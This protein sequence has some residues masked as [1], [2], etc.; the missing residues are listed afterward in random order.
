MRRF[1]V[2]I[3]M[4]VLGLM[5]CR[6][7]A[8]AQQNVLRAGVAVSK[9]YPFTKGAEYLAAKLRERTSGRVTLEVFPDAVL[10][11]EPELFEQV[12]G[13][14]LDISVVSANYIGVFA[15]EGNL[16]DLPFLLK[17]LAHRE[18]VTE[19]PIG[20]QY[21]EIIEKKTG[22]V[23]LGYFGGSVRNVLC[24]NRAVNSIQ[25]LQGIKIRAQPSAMI[26]DAWKAIGMVPVPLAYPE[27]YLALKT[28]VVECAEN[29]ALTFSLAKWAEVAKN[30]GLTQHTITI[31][32]LVM[33]AKSLTKLSS[34][35]QE[36]LRTVAREAVKYEVNLEVE[37]DKM[38]S[39][40]LAQKYGVKTTTPDRQPFIE[41][42]KPIAE[43]FAKSVGLEATLQEIYK[44]A[45]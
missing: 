4:I 28:G 26:V 43:E 44:M 31:K 40:L 6:G 27:V 12:R 1:I 45:K 33:S 30:I 2:G 41:R 32:P 17:D 18:A 29:E 5:I 13:G 39:S 3:G 25:D 16:W 7:W 36:I 24:R 42:T 11:S 15:K 9:D 22:V 23:V 20:R 21:A 14:G 10:G 34:A 19:G 35:D 8:E 37:G 38:T